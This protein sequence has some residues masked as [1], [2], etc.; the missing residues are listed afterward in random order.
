MPRK[1]RAR[2]AYTFALATLAGIACVLAAFMFVRSDLVEREKAAREAER[3]RELLSV[4]L[5][6]VGDAVIAT[7]RASRI[8]FLN[9]VAE[10]VTGWTNA[11]AAGKRLDEVFQ[12]IN[13]QTRQPVESP[14]V[15]VLRE[16]KIVGLANHT[17]LLRRNGGEIPIDD[18]GAPIRDRAGQ[19]LGVII[20]FRDVSDL[21]KAERVMRETES[22]FRTMADNAPVLVWIA[23]TQ[24]NGIWFNKTWLSFV[25]RTLAQENGSGWRGGVHHDDFER[26]LTTFARA[27]DA[28]E[29]FRMEYRLRRHDG[30]YRWLLD[31]GVPLYGGDKEFTGYIGTCIDITDRREVEAARKNSS[32]RKRKLT[33]S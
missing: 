12:I 29:E 3:Q 27:F 7:D 21:K 25:G 23:D 18:S 6:S 9:E 17:V 1:V 11:E 33:P 10:Q 32:S 28:R 8:T 26:C 24:Q 19:I 4:T 31:H 14:A 15:K 5:T 20:V 22:R 2:A 16:G 13:E 30:A